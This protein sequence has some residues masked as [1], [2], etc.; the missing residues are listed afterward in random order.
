MTA[1][2][3][4]L[5]V[6][7]P[8]LDQC[9][10]FGVAPR[11][12]D[13]RGGNHAS[14]DMDDVDNNLAKELNKLSFEERENILHEIHGV[15]EITKETPE[16]VSRCVEKLL[17]AV[18]RLPQRRRVAL[19]RAIFLKPSM[20]EK[21]IRFKLMFLR[22]HNH[23]PDKAAWCLAKYFEDKLELFG[24]DKLVKKITL[25]DLSEED[26]EE[27]HKGVST[28]LPCR[29]RSGRPISFVDCTKMDFS[30]YDDRM[31]RCSWYHIMSMLEDEATQLKGVSTIM[32][33]I[34]QLNKAAPFHKV[35][36]IM[37]R[38]GRV[39]SN[40]PLRA[41][42]S[43]F[44]Y[45]N[46]SMVP[47]VSTIRLA[48]GKKFG[49]Y[50]RTHYGS[51]VEVQYALQ[52]YGITCP[53]AEKS[54][55]GRDTFIELHQ[56]H[57]ERRLFKDR[58][59]MEQMLQESEATGIIPYPSPNDVLVGRGVPYQNFS[60]NRRLNDL[61]ES[62]FLNDY[63]A[64]AMDKFEKTC[65][66]LDVIKTVKETLGG[67]FLGRTP[68]GWTVVTETAARK[69]VNSAFRSRLAKKSKE[70]KMSLSSY[71]KKSN[72]QMD[73]AEYAV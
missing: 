13:L 4:C 1:P 9:L 26:M 55:H 70:T 24:E 39:L 52:S 22:A 62:K 44:C 69:K 56:R 21:D 61:I 58:Q 28:V 57:T 47:I 20:K 35:Q 33:C 2:K 19:D 54:I 41:N 46:P 59:E 11:N 72:I 7:P 66:Y 65:L 48:F 29:D 15:A 3:P 36:K 40:M 60:G 25:D 30:H 64:T 34:G 38:D 8:Q 53:L 12:T 14:E 18:D 71:V 49:L 63:N 43:H 37:R 32:C 45:D 67:R 73:T 51:D 16:F 5:G 42:S 27:W 10:T 6:M 31:L 17:E 50:H 68:E 23:D